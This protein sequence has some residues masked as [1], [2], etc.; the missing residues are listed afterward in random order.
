LTRVFAGLV[1]AAVFAGA[2]AGGSRAPRLTGTLAFGTGQYV[3][4]VKADGSDGH[5]LAPG[6][7]P[8][9]STSGELAYTLNGIWVARA[10][11]SRR[12]H[13]VPRFAEYLTYT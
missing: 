9:F 2:A 5:A 12:R 7:Y 8:A 1:I 4:A 6:D 10:D 11:G 3:F 13:I